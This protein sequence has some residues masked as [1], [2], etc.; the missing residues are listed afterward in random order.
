MRKWR[1]RWVLRGRVVRARNGS[2]GAPGRARR[3]RRRAMSI[4]SLYVSE[5]LSKRFSGVVA[6][7]GVGVF[8]VADHRSRK[9]W[10]LQDGVDDARSA[11]TW[12]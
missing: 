9:A 8:I 3:A 7:A 1:F 10:P 2:L 5:V 11:R 6:A 4:G 12:E